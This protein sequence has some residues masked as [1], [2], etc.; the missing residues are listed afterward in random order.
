[1]RL[2]RLSTG[3]PH[4]Q[5][6]KSVFSTQLLEY[7]VPKYQ[8]SSSGYLIQ[9][10]SLEQKKLEDYSSAAC[11][12]AVQNP[13]D[14]VESTTLTTGKRQSDAEARTR[15]RTK[16]DT[17]LDLSIQQ[18]N[19][20]CLPDERPCQPWTSMSTLAPSSAPET[21]SVSSLSPALPPR[22]PLPSSRI[23]RHCLNTIV[24]TQIASAQDCPSAEKEKEHDTAEDGQTPES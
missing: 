7:S 14:I 5:Y 3:V 9:F 24:S 13:E 23:A 12:K 4:E 6:V 8:I 16:R 15:A 22:R 1:M 21:E 20:Q 17:R 19:G 11:Q 2:V 18:S 10:S